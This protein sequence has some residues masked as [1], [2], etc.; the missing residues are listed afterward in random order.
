MA[1]EH[2]AATAA[3]IEAA[4]RLMSWRRWWLELPPDRDLPEDLAAAL[5]RALSALERIE[6][7]R[8]SA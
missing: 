7:A 5:E 1:A 6:T 2:A 8:A 3:V 4:N